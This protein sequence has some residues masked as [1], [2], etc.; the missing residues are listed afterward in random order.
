MATLGT[1]GTIMGL[2]A[3]FKE[4]QPQVKIIAVEPRLG[5]RLQGLKNMKESYK[6]GIFD[7]SA[8]DEIVEVDDDRAFDTARQLA[9]QEGLLVGMSSGA[10]MRTALDYARSLDTGLVVAI[11]PD[12]G[13]R[14]L[15]TPLFTP[16]ET[17]AGGKKSRLRF[18]N[19]MTK[20]KEVFKPQKEGRV[21]FYSC[22]PTAYE[23]ANLSLC[24][25]F[26]VADLI[27]RY[28]ESR[29]YTVNSYMNFTDLDDN[30]ISGA[31]K[32]GMELGASPGS[33]STRF[34]P[35]S[36]PSASGTPPATPGPPSTSRT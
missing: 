28:L 22:G 3:W 14:Y 6:P 21:T 5:H 25:R 4:F 29:G 11:L 24:R 9:R 13:E 16:E 35:T 12:G 18:F 1:S 30:T 27:V 32:A 10:A 33:T 23:P 17:Q 31:E 15:S 26:V 19:T 7:K 8:P 36:T 2:C 34:S 20:K